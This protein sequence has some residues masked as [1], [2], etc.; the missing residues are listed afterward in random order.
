[1]DPRVRISGRK[2]AITHFS[3][4]SSLVVLLA[5]VQV[6]SVNLWGQEIPHPTVLVHLR[7]S[8]IDSF[9]ECVR[10]V[11]GK[12]VLV[13]SSVNPNVSLDPC[14]GSM[15][16]LALALKSRGIKIFPS[17]DFVFLIPSKFFPPRPPDLSPYI[18]TLAWKEVT[19]IPSIRPS[20]DISSTES[21]EI[22]RQAFLRARLVP[23]E[24]SL[25]PP[26]S[27]E[28]KIEINA[29]VLVGTV[30]PNGDRP[31]VTWINGLQT[32]LTGRLVYGVIRNNNYT[33]LWDSPLFNSRGQVYFK[34][35]NG[36]QSLEIVIQSQNCGNDCSDEVVIFDKNGRELTRQKQCDTVPHAFDEE[37]G[38]C[39]IKGQEIDLLDGADGTT[40]IRVRNWASDNK[41]HL[42]KLQNGT[43]N[44]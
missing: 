3:R 16:E 27:T 6:A 28:I 5:T 13:D 12:A 25:L 10:R 34:D 40:A 17:G 42:F 29:F 37:D 41:D 18:K 30:E 1:L 38:V 21:Q 36:D 2:L 8:A 35:V 15:Q 19:I 20:P 14:P 22:G 11:Y 43:F 33:M 32:F 4:F 26:G 7:P 44:R 23:V 39:A 9:T 31:V 24:V